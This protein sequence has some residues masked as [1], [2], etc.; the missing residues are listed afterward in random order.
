LAV[1]PALR[2]ANT[3]TNT[4]TSLH[5]HPYNEASDAKHRQNTQLVQS[6]TDLSRC[7]MQRFQ[8][9]LI[10]SEGHKLWPKLNLAVVDQ[11][12]FNF[13]SLK[14]GSEVPIL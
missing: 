5:V 13:F 14:S 6:T 4:K 11:Y 3:I 12:N 2:C 9:Q 10:K 7:H 8:G 1:S